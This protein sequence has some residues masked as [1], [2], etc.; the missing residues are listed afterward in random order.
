M[1]SPANKLF[2]A[3]ALSFLL[4]ALSCAKDGALLPTFEGDSDV[5]PVEDAL[6]LVTKHAKLLYPE[7]RS[8]LNL[9]V[10]DAI[11]LTKKDLSKSTRSIAS[12]E[13]P[14]TTLYIFNFANNSGYAVASANRK[15]GN[16]LF[17]ITERGSL[18]A[19]DFAPIHTRASGDSTGINDGTH[20][21]TDL[22]TA[23][24]MANEIAPPDSTVVGGGPG[25][26]VGPFLMTKWG[27]TISPFNDSTY[28]NY[29]AGCV[30]IAVA[31]IMAYEEYANT[32]VFN[33]V[34]CDWDDMKTVYT[35]PSFNDPGSTMGRIQVANFIKELGSEDNC[36][37]TYGPDGSHGTIL[38][39]K[40]TLNNYGYSATITPLIPSSTFTHH[41]HSKVRTQLF[42]GHPVYVRGMRDTSNGHAWVID[43][44]FAG[45]YHINWGWRGKNDGYFN[46]G[47]FSI[48]DRLSTSSID[49]GTMRP[50]SYNYSFR[51]QIIT[52]T[53]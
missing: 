23:S 25:G 51:F 19:E 16:T 10:S 50:E 49:P 34:L 8:N 48:A 18:S 37:I 46:G 28:F 26:I 31:Q 5:I 39:A 24:I 22:L 33:G 32:M 14:D 7:T 20:F 17:C 30:V 52:Y 11:T 40:S 21:I 6:E 42:S 15:Y 53:L 9:S 47:V 1:K 12:S 27:Q 44:C 13:I 3:A 38:R 43:G 29:P 41:M 4:L 36:D 2:I 45:L 35:Y